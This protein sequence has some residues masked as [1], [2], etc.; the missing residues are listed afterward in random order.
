LPTVAASS[1]ELPFSSDTFEGAW[2]LGVL[3]VIEDKQ[4]ALAELQRVIEPGGRIVLYS[5]MK[6]EENLSEVPEVDHFERPGSVEEIAS[7][8]GLRTTS[9]D[10]VTLPKIPDSW[11]DIRSRVRG[12]LWELHI[13]DPLLERVELDLARINR[14]TSSRQVEP[15]EFVFEKGTA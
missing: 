7:S 4:A 1:K 14:L 10:R 3:E 2:M 6:T 15:W 11:R 9:S 13:D 12:R 5:F 8:V